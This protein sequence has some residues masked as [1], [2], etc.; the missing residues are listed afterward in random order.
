[1]VGYSISTYGGVAIIAKHD[2]EATEVLY[3]DTSE[4]VAASFN[5]TSSK[6]SIII[7]CFYRPTDN[8][9]DYADDLCKDIHNLY[10]NNRNSSIWLGGD[11][12][13]PDIDCRQ[14][15]SGA[16]NIQFP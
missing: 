8:N 2:M 16:T 7:G 4:F 1:M 3:S 5:T 13:L 10:S 14:T 6:K 15:T 12:N 11:A 9:I